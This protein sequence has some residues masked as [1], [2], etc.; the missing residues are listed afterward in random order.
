MSAACG[1]CA[2]L[3]T[4]RRSGTPTS[5]T[6]RSLWWSASA[7][8]RP[9]SLARAFSRS[10]ISS[11]ILRNAA[12]L[13]GICRSRQGGDRLP[14]DRLLQEPGTGDLGRSLQRDYSSGSIY[15]YFTHSEG[16]G[17]AT[18]DAKPKP[19][20]SPVTLPDGRVLLDLQNDGRVMVTL[21][22]LQPVF[23]MTVAAAPGS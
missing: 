15:D 3:A 16:N 8:F 22:R 5:A 11:G 10:T 21:E 6:R 20:G 9:G 18:E 17:A 12:S 23:H 7:S 14:P 19:A 1:C 13:T 4:S 2:R